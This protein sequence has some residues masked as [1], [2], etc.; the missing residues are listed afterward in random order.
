MQ[1]RQPS[2]PDPSTMSTE[3]VR[4]RLQERGITTNHYTAQSHAR[5]FILPGSVETAL[6]SP[7][8]PVSTDDN[9]FVLY[10]MQEEDD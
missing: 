10:A 8:V 6:A 1:P 4:S 2:E 3:V 9:P 7:N 5:L